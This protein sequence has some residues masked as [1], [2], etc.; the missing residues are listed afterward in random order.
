MHPAGAAVDPK[1]VPLHL[2]WQS[3]P[4]LVFLA[5]AALLPATVLWAAAL[6]NSLGI[7]HLVA[8]LPAPA[9]AT[10]RPER[11][12]LID[13]FLTLTLAL[14]LL[15]VLSGLLATVSFDLR[16][17]SWEITAKLRLPS[18][19]WTLVQL[20]A[21]ALLLLGSLLFLAMAGHLAADC[22]F[23]TDCVSG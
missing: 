20:A 16:I 11:L 17:T 21:A 2:H 7:T 13:A 1:D 4:S 10:S 6:A 15:A 5:L 22:V 3:R 19:P 12:L 23:G 8:Y 14:P 9:T 18:P